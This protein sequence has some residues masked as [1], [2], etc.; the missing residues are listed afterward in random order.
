MAAIAPLLSTTLLPRPAAHTFQTISKSAMTSLKASDFGQVRKRF[1][2]VFK[3][4]SSRTRASSTSSLAVPSIV[5]AMWPT[6]SPR[7]QLSAL[8]WDAV[9]ECILPSALKSPTSL[10]SVSRSCKLR[11]W[12]PVA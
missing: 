9:S 4:F 3:S 10:A 7:I 5:L 1:A 6:T 12:S 8:R 2:D 11:G